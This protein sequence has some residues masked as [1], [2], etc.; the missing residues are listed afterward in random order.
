ML[1]LLLE[2]KILEKTSYLK[3]RIQFNS[4]RH[5]NVSSSSNKEAVAFVPILVFQDNAETRMFNRTR[6]S[7]RVFKSSWERVIKNSCRSSYDK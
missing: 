5:D 1:G 4:I 2:K 6:N 7:D 3:L